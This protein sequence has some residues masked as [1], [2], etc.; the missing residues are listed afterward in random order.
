M[1]DRVLEERD[2]NAFDYLEN[3]IAKWSYIDLQLDRLG[4][5]AIMWPVYINPLF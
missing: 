1:I 2:T 3:N 4:D 5:A